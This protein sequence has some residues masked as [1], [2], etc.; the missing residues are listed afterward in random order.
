MATSRWTCQP[1]WSWLVGQNPS[2]PATLWSKRVVRGD[3]VVEAPLG[4]LMH[5]GYGPGAEIFGRLRLSIC[6]DGAD[7]WSGYTVELGTGEKDVYTLYRRHEAVAS[8][9]DRLP[10]WREVHNAW[11]DLRLEREGDEVRATFHGRP[12]LS[13]RDAQ[14]LGDG[15]VCLWTESNGIVT[16]YVAVYGKSA[17]ARIAAA[18]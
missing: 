8:V 6:G 4:P 10:H 17:A 12:L 11:F 2:G 1:Q 15:Q 9:P 7:P 3:Q 13:W 18:R 5:G 14:P 16:P